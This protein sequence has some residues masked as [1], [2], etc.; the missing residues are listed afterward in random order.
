[1]KSRLERYED[2]LIFRVTSQ[3]ALRYIHCFSSIAFLRTSNSTVTSYPFSKAYK[4]FLQLPH[5]PFE[6]RLIDDGLKKAIRSCEVT[7]IILL[8][9]SIPSSPDSSTLSLFLMQM[10]QSTP[11]YTIIVEQNLVLYEMRSVTSNEATHI[12]NSEYKIEASF[13]VSCLTT[14][15]SYFAN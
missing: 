5:F 3:Q 14:R 6:Y 11:P 7:L 9:H 4:S 15:S 1:M 10:T 12:Y 2:Q 13:N 8:S